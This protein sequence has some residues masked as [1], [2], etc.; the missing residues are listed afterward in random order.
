M[1]DSPLPSERRQYRRFSVRVSVMLLGD[2]VPAVCR[3]LSLGGLCVE[4]KNIRQVGAPVPIRIF[5]PST[6]QQIPALCKTMRHVLGPD[7]AIEGLGLRFANVDD[8]LKERVEKLLISLVGPEVKEAI[9]TPVDLTDIA[10]IEHEVPSTP[11]LVELPLDVVLEE[12]TAPGAPPNVGESPGAG[13]AH[14]S[15]RRPTRRPMANGGGDHGRG[16]GDIA[17]ERHRP[18][19]ARRHLGGWIAF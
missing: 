10:I 12:T 15:A 5:D 18:P 17:H 8:A 2:S 6:K 19:R 7:G 14:A 16:P 13:W 4:T 1:A 9:E 3:D 11:E